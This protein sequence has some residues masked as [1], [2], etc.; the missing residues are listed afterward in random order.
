MNKILSKIKNMELTKV[1]EKIAE[2]FTDNLTTIGFYTSST[3]ANEIGVSDSSVVRFIHKLGY[4]GYSEFRTDMN[5]GIAEKFEK[6]RQESLMPSEKFAQTKES[7]KNDDLVSDI[8]DNILNNLEQTLSRLDMKVVKQVASLLISSKRK[9]IC[10]FRGTASCATYLA[11]KLIL[12]LPNV[13]ALIHA[14]SNV[15]EQTFDLRKGD[16]LFVYSFPRYSEINKVIMELAKKNGANIILIT[17]NYASPLAKL[18]DIVITANV[19]GRGFVN[20]Y[21][22][23]MCISDI[24]LL[25]VSKKI[26]AK[27][28]ERMGKIDS[29][30]NKEKLY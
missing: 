10:G 14:D 27:D 13:R 5:L 8:S 2:Y 26:G 20:S 25:A 19:K 1:D 24:V 4:K 23:P 17:D 9:C 7:L 28:V 15:I 11:N 6:T 22:A 18:A 29:I 21:I 16:C 3:L 30:M 12:M